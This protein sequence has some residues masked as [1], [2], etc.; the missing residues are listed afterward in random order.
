MGVVEPL[1]P[2]WLCHCKNF[3]HLIFCGASIKKRILPF[4]KIILCY[5]TFSCPYN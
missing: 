2:P 5:K 1:E 4:T 3:Q